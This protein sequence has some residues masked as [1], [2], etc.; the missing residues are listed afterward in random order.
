MFFYIECSTGWVVIVENQDINITVNPINDT[1]YKDT[2]TI[3]GKI[4]D[5]NC[6][7]LYNINA[8][9]KING[10]IYK[11]KTEKI[12]GEIDNLTI[13]DRYFN[14]ISANYQHDIWQKTTKFYK[15]IIL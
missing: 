13:V 2:I 9:I 5:A 3:S 1:V 15:A 11:A 7:G 14:F 6:Y 8:I 10:K 4:T 12:E